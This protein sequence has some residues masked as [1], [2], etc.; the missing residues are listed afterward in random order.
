MVSP[1]LGDCLTMFFFVIAQPKP[2]YAP[3]RSDGE[4]V[5]CVITGVREAHNSPFLTRR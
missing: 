1:D 4:H 3:A 2:Q 5:R